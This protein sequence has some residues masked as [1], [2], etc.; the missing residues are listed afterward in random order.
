MK[1]TVITWNQFKNAVADHIKQRKG[2]RMCR[3]Q[4]NSLWPLVTSFH[5]QPNV[6]N[7]SDYF[8][9][10]VTALADQVGTIEN[11][12]IDVSNNEVNG[13]FAAYLQHHGLPTPLLDWTMSPYIAAYFAFS[14]VDD[15][16]PRSDCVSIYIFNH[17]EWISEWEQIFMYD[18]PTKH[19]SI[20]SPKSMGNK[21]QIV[22]QSNYIFTNVQ[23]VG[24]Y[25]TSCG[26]KKNKTYLEKYNISV[27]E[28]TDVMIELETMGIT[29]Y[30][31]FQ[32]T[33]ALCK[34]YREAIFRTDQVGKT[35]SEIMDG[36]FKQIP[37]Q[38]KQSGTP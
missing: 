17:S 13:S 11:R 23:D 30:S 26:A 6:L 25:V 33:E 3:G 8:Q 37:Q 29:A 9:K 35:P 10:I 2:P 31:L 12:I 7:L 16:S 32:N 21:R 24:E 22:Q 38:F 19:V 36:L 14:G 28:R 27:K 34:Y 1:E 15:R 18:S 20:L 5:R 4:S